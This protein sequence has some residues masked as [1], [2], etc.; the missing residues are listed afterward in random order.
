VSLCAFEPAFGMVEGVHS[1]E[2]H[3]REEIPMARDG[4]NARAESVTRVL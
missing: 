4:L 2:G 3:G 1:R